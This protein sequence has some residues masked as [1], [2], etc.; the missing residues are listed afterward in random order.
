MLYVFILAQFYCF[1][2]C[3]NLGS[4]HRLTDFNETAYLTLRWLFRNK[5]IFKNLA[6]YAIKIQ[7]IYILVNTNLYYNIYNNN[8]PNYWILVQQ[9]LASFQPNWLYLFL[10][11]LICPPKQS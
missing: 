7:Y 10:H 6:T 8:K 5:K 2:L 9:K 4:Y 11:K 3:T 1:Y